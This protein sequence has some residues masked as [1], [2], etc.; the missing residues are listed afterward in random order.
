VLGL[1]PRARRSRSFSFA[2]HLSSVELSATAILAIELWFAGLSERYN[3]DWVEE[4]NCRN[5][6]RYLLE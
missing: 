6:Y 3:W 4:L 2:T 1:V 5:T